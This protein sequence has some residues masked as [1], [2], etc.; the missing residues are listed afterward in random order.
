MMPIKGTFSRDC[1]ALL[2]VW[3]DRALFGDEPL[4]VFITIYCY[5][6]FNVEFNFLQRYFKE[7]ALSNVIGA[8]L[9]QVCHRL[10]PA[11]W[12]IYYKG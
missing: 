4:I 6:V 5:L 2:V 10:L 3:M 1:N 7:V 11:F 12:Q 9:L 8:T